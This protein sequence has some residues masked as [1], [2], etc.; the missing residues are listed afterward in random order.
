MSAQSRDQ[1]DQR[2]VKAYVKLL[3]EV[4]LFTP[5][6]EAFFPGKID[7]SQ[8]GFGDKLTTRLVGAPTG[9]LRNWQAIQMW[10][11]N[12]PRA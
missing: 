3:Q 1:E 8:M 9:D 7:P 2:L 11:D 12:I 4:K 6:H 10:A 5:R